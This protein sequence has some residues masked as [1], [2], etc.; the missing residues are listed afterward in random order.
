M[1]AGDSELCAKPSS[2]SIAF[3]VP[4]TPIYFKVRARDVDGNEIRRI[5]ETIKLVVTRG[6]SA[7]AVFASFN[8][9]TVQ[10][11]AGI[12]AHLVSTAG[13]YSVELQTSLQSDHPQQLKFAVVC[14]SG[15]VVN[16]ITGVCE[17]ENRCTRDDQYIDVQTL[18]CKQKP[19]I[20]VS[21][22]S[23]VVSIQVLKTKQSKTAFGTAE[24]RL[25]SGDV[26]PKAPVLWTV[27]PPIDT[28]WLV[29]SQ[30]S[31]TVDGKSPAFLIRV[32]VDASQLNDTRGA[33][34]PSVFLQITGSTRHMWADGLATS[35]VTFVGGSD[36][37][38]FS[39]PVSV[40]VR[41]IASLTD[42]DVTISAKASGKPVLRE[43][44]PAG[45]TLIVTVEVLDCDGLIINRPD[46]RL[47]LRLTSSLGG[48]TPRSVSLIYDSER[49]RPGLFEAELPATFFGEAGT[50]ILSVHAEG[51]SGEKDGS[52]VNLVLTVVDASG[53]L[54]VLG[55]AVGLCRRRPTPTA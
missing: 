25:T 38:S 39:L 28:T 23:M 13:N 29:C 52:S 41:A 19:A 16:D 8:A 32:T 6:A 42:R 31:G 12:P 44:V 1:F 3:S 7:T 11:E 22:S 4:T 45:T 49:G 24:V 35:K 18:Q 54:V 30:L 55:Y 46:Q 17:P 10:Y 48:Y 20:A 5:G 26:D 15:Y 33:S 37:V 51:G 21:A 47:D 36:L 40:S 53:E 43:G 50:Y 9:D 27:T 14:A 34:M 2:G